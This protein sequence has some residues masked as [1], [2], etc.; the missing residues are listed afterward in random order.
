MECTSLYII[1]GD[2]TFI[3]RTHSRREGCITCSLRRLGGF[4][5]LLDN[6]EVP[7]FPNFAESCAQFYFVSFRFLFHCSPL[8]PL[9]L[10]ITSSLQL[11]K[12]QAVMLASLIVDISPLSYYSYLKSSASVLKDRRCGVFLRFGWLAS[13]F[14]S[15]TQ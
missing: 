7:F 15:T 10:L 8:S 3:A 13:R 11:A 4:Q 1:L 9:P 5:V 12:T 14:S 2:L 6:R